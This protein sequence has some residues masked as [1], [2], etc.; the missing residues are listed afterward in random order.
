MWS[1]WGSC[2]LKETFLISL[3]EWM[4][5]LPLLGCQ[6]GKLRQ[7][8]E[9]VWSPV[10]H[11]CRGF[12]H[13]TAG[14]ISSLVSMVVFFLIKATPP[15]IL[16]TLLSWII[17]LILPE[18]VKAQGSNRWSSSLGLGKYF[19]CSVCKCEDLSLAPSPTITHS[20]NSTTEMETEESLGAPLPASLD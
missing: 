2:R 17:L 13:H 12:Y 9:N 10:C 18:K 15:R 11:V 7:I 16:H 14:H 20:C 5:F 8:S 19:C 4:A 1:H 3:T 6:N